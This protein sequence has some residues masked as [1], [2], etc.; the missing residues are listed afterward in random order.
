MTQ[1]DSAS[2]SARRDA[3]VNAFPTPEKL[4]DGLHLHAADACAL[5]APGPW[6]ASL[7]R[8]AFILLGSALTKALVRG[9]LEARQPCIAGCIVSFADARCPTCGRELV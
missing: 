7:V 1:L 9:V 5:W 2:V 4:A 8:H 3:I 6:D